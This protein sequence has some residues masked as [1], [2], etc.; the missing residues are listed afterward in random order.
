MTNY[1][2]TAYLPLNTNALRT[3]TNKA[4]VVSEILA[5]GLLDES[6]YQKYSPPF[7]SAGDLMVYGATFAF[8]PASILWTCIN[9]GRTIIVS[10][11]RGYIPIECR[12]RIYS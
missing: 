8:Y 7:Y 10:A 12:P 1:K 9:E 5:N 2:F 4:Y 11:E 3:N 6:K